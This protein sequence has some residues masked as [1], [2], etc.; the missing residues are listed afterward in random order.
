MKIPRTAV[1]TLV[2]SVSGFLALV[3]Q[4]NYVEQAMIPAKNDR[5]TLGFG[6]TFHEDGRA[7]KLGEKTDP[8]RALIKAK[9]HID[10]EEISF[11]ASLPN[12][13]LYQPEYD[14]YMDWVYQYGTGAWWN[15][16]IRKN[17]LVSNYQGACDALLKFRFMGKY[18]CSTLVAGK[19]NKR[20]YGVWTRQLK[21][22]KECMSFQ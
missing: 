21:R 9:A 15:S 14:L 11:R 18:D 20:C 1:A 7:V 22:H 12:V 4:E 13:F 2:L 19:P 3:M 17:L 5:P 8:V 6:S 16:S 10:R